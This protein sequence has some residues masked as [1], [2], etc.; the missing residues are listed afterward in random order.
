MEA[1]QSIIRI[2]WHLNRG[3]A[4]IGD[5]D[6]MNP[7]HQKHSIPRCLCLHFQGDNLSKWSSI[8][9][10][11]VKSNNGDVHRSN[12]EQDNEKFISHKEMKQ[13]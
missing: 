7:S 6:N 4:G 2:G 8:C 13:A 9:S 12:K 11:V 1:N 3:H 5:N 10:D